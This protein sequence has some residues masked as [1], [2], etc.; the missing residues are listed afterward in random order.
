MSSIA[1]IIAHELNVKLVQVDAAEGAVADVAAGPAVRA[2]AAED[3]AGARVR[4]APGGRVSHADARSSELVLQVNELLPADELNR[5]PG[6]SPSTSAGVDA[7]SAASWLLL[8]ARGH[9][10]H[11]PAQNS[12]DVR[13]KVGPQPRP[14]RCLTRRPPSTD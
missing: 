3:E 2:V 14:A 11:F 6:A 7:G 4:L 12:L 13:L 5:S 10:L 9:G 8:C 1:Q